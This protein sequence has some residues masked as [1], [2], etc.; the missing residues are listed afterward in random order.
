MV[1]FAGFS[2]VVADSASIHLFL[3]SAA[4]AFHFYCLNYSKVNIVSCFGNLFKFKSRIQV[5][6]LN[7]TGHMFVF[8]PSLDNFDDLQFLI[9]KIT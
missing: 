3:L 2:V 1:L 6:S 9:L 5:S 7:K 8:Q 4:L